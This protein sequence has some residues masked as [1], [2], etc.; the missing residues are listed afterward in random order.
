MRHLLGRP[1]T[2]HRS[3]HPKREPARIVAS[4]VPHLVASG[5]AES[6][7]VQAARSP[8]G[9]VDEDHQPLIAG[10]V[11]IRNSVAVRLVSQLSKRI[12]V[13][14]VKAS[15]VSCG[16]SRFFCVLLWF[17]PL[18]SEGLS[19]NVGCLESQAARASLIHKFTNGG[20][21]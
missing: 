4:R 10:A 19:W 11:R 8:C 20:Y 15:P 21:S 7:K 17:M 14:F 5:R 6:G 9:L 2:V 3:L 13:L 12:G 16:P 18:G 1:T